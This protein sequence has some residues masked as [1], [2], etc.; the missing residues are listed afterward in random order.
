[1]IV[2]ILLSIIC[3]L[4]EVPTSNLLS[5]PREIRDDIVAH[6]FRAGDLAIL[7]ISRQLY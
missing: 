1:M 2:Q 7:R 5:L 6:L 4:T 3:P